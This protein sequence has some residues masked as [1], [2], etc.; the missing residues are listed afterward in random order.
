MGNLTPHGITHPVTLET[1]F[2]GGYPGMALD[3]HARVWFST[4]GVFQRSQFG[5]TIGLLPKGTRFGVG[6]DVEVIIE[7]EL[8]GPAWKSGG[9]KP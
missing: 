1:T 5:F 9:A 7:A 3:P 2:N 8:N 6:D 4:H